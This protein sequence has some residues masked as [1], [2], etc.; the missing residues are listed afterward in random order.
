MKVTKLTLA[1]LSIGFCGLLN[2]TI[3]HAMSTADYINA[4]KP[5]IQPLKGQRGVGGTS[6]SS[7]S[8]DSLEVALRL[9]FALNSADLSTE[10]VEHLH[11]LNAVTELQNLAVAL[12]DESLR[13]F[14]YL[15]EGHTCNLGTAEHNLALSKRRAYAVA[16]WLT[17]NTSLSPEQFEV[18]WYGESCPVVANTD[19]SARKEN[20]RV[21]IKNTQQK[22]A[23]SLQNKPA[24][25]QITRYKNGQKESVND[26]DTLESGE[27]Y[28]LAFQTASM[29]YA[30]V[31]QMDSSGASVLLFPGSK[32]PQQTNPVTPG[33][34][35][36]MPGG[37]DLFYLDDTIGS[38]Q[39][40]L[41]VFDTPVA[42]PL[43][44]CKTAF[45][46]DTVAQRG[47]GGVA[48]I[49]PAPENVPAIRTDD[50]LQL[51]E[52]MPDGRTRGLGGITKPDQAIAS[53]N[54][55]ITSLDNACKGY[56]LKRFFIHK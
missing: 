5:S 22:V 37:T 43:L 10:A 52:I 12:E 14:K 45:Q 44:A 4:L 38:E 26:G 7:A 24:T 39:I 41:M 17:K 13:Q 53:T 6:F 11:T 30:Y 29:P 49:K 51:C 2:C 28:S 35:Y 9:Q 36:Q 55:S 3:S 50:D 42:D 19:E 47:V 18:S 54:N 33:L 20:R 27:H 46:D 34:T 32:D 56:F 21:V 1:I 23:V 15:V 48:V 16:E 31:C 8:Q 25:I 40:M